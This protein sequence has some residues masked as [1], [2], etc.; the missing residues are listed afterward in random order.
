MSF[1]WASRRGACLSDMPVDPTKVGRLRE[2]S[3]EYVGEKALLLLMPRLTKKNVNLD[4]EI[5]MARTKVYDVF[6]SK[7]KWFSI[8]KPRRML[9]SNEI[10]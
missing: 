4:M 8:V 9:R 5:R 7:G 2:S 3:S 1:Q 6:L 10:A